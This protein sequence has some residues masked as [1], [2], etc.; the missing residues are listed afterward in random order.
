MIFDHTL[1]SAG[2][3]YDGHPSHGWTQ[4]VERYKW[5]EDNCAELAKA[6]SRRP[7]ESRRWP[8][9]SGSIR[10]RWQTPS[11]GGTA[12][13]SGH[14]AEFG[15]KL[16]LEP[17]G[18]G[19]FFAIELSPSMLNTQGGPRRNEKARSCGP[20]ARRSHA[21]TAPENWLNY[22]YFTRALAISANASPSA[23]FRP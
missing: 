2:P 14:D 22:I 6:G 9:S 11:A 1:F 15:R 3:L 5:S 18:E 8:P 10:R 7:T 21:S 23:A 20:T 19:P 12:P 4:I 16:M 17:I 13:A